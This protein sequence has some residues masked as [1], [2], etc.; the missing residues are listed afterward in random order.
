[1][2]ENTDWKKS[3]F[4]FIHSH[5]NFTQN[6]NENAYISYS[7]K[8]LKYSQ[9]LAEI[10]VFPIVHKYYYQKNNP[11]KNYSVIQN[12]AYCTIL[13]YFLGDSSFAP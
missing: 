1:M 6:R 12:T 10:Q 9:F 7:W 11:F 5:W 4:F 3:N 13:R 2:Q 8:L